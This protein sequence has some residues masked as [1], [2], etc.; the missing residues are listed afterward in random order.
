MYWCY[1]LLTPLS[2]SQTDSWV[3]WTC[4]QCTC[5]IDIQLVIMWMQL[6]NKIA[7]IW[8]SWF[9]ESLWEVT[10]KQLQC[11]VCARNLLWTVPCNLLLFFQE[12]TTK[13][14]QCLLGFDSIWQ[15]MKVFI[16]CESCVF[17]I[18]TVRLFLF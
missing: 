4:A 5:R 1:I 12:H 11:I 15:L 8:S 9:M 16:L 2:K 13:K 10:I 3:Q 7:Y 18:L 6:G 14:V 17:V